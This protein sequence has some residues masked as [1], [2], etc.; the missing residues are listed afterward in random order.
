[1]YY[2][3]PQVFQK[4]EV[5]PLQ[6]QLQDINW[7]G[8]GLIQNAAK[9]TSTKGLEHDLEDGNTRWN[10]LNKKVSLSLGY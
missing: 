3:W 2:L 1:L 10:T 9:G 6:T 4:E 8:Q 7:L 5:D